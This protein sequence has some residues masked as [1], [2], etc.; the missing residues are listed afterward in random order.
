M[1][2]ET[3]GNVSVQDRK[4]ACL[5]KRGI[6]Q[7]SVQIHRGSTQQC[8]RDV[9]GA[10]GEGRRPGQKLWERMRTPLWLRSLPQPTSSQVCQRRTQ[11][12]ETQAFHLGSTI[13]DNF[14]HRKAGS[15]AT[16]D[17]Q[18]PEVTQWHRGKTALS[19]G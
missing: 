3:T 14:R 15:E 2:I 7:E 12:E 18:S 13:K 10:V 4:R 8:K 1:A 19:L 9:C 11:S 5:W 16:L 6:S 17:P